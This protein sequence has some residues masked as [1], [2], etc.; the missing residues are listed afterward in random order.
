MTDGYL[1]DGS[2]AQ[3]VDC[4]TPAGQLRNSGTRGDQP[5]SQSSRSSQLFERGLGYRELLRTPSSEMAVR[6]AAQPP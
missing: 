1:P 5:R 2:A 4:R 6:E 3:F